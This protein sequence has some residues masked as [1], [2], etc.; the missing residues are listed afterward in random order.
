M[1]VCETM[2]SNSFKLLGVGF[3][4]VLVNTQSTPILFPSATKEMPR[5]NEYHHPIALRV[6]HILEPRLLYSILKVGNL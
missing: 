2:V 1:E 5:E 4:S 3:V 6:R